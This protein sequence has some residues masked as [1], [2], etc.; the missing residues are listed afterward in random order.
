M[1]MLCALAHV[2]KPRVEC[3]QNRRAKARGWYHCSKELRSLPVMI[4][5]T[6]QRGHNL[7]TIIHELAHHIVWERLSKRLANG[8]VQAPRSP[9]PCH[10]CRP[11]P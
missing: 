11:M 6:S 4:A 5:N 10:L 9:V 7:R 3:V 1:G 8:E 2:P